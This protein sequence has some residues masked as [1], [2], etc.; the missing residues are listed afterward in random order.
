MTLLEKIESRDAVIGIL[1]LGYVGIPLALS[2]SKAGFKVIGFD[3][4]EERIRQ[5]NQ[6]TSP[7]QHVSSDDIRFMA[8]RGFQPTTD[9]SLAGECDAL[10][11][12]VPT[13]LD[14]H[15]E[16]DLSFVI[17]TMSSIAPHLRQGQLLSL[18]STTWPG[19]T[20]K[21]PASASITWR[22]SEPN[23]NRSLPDTTYP[24]VS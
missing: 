9:F 11:I 17:A 19:T 14:A 22:P 1:G 8:D 13:P 21:S 10:I 7:I 5:L 12:C 4:L 20:K 18:E 3:I 15:R 2:I 24:Y 16:P 23:S 6:F